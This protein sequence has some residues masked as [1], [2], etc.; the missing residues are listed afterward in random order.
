V[1]K[2][3]DVIKTSDVG[4]RSG[5]TPKRADQAPDGPPLAAQHVAVGPPSGAERAPSRCQRRSRLATG[6]PRGLDDH[7]G[8]RGALYRDY[9]RAVA[10]R[11]N[12]VVG[13]SATTPARDVL[14]ALR[15]CG[16]LRVE[17]YDAER[18]QDRA[19]RG[20]DPRRAR[21]IGRDVAAIRSQLWAAETRIQELASR[22]A[23]PAPYVS[24]MDQILAM[25]P[26]R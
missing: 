22:D 10:A 7:R 2:E 25:G 20:N 9:L 4:L 16:R 24:P 11:H 8:P 23:K 15:T 6:L 14:D 17:L 21:V 1:T 5:V 18:D 26:A 19:R 12:L 13:R 3:K